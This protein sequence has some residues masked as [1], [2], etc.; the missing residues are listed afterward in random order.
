MARS[1]LS[2]VAM[3]IKIKFKVPALYGDSSYD[4]KN[5]TSDTSSCSS[6]YSSSCSSRSSFPSLSGCSPKLKTA[7]HVVLPLFTFLQIN[8]WLLSTWTFPPVPRYLRNINQSYLKAAKMYIWNL[9]GGVWIRESIKG[10]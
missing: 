9:P 7:I 5:S 10:G 3:D 2:I 6:S 1:L 4:S 8:T